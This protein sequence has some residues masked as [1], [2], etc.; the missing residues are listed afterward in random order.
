MLHED[1][2]TDGEKKKYKKEVKALVKLIQFKF[3]VVGEHLV[4]DANQLPST[5]T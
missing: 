1:V 2:K 5:M 4:Y 3:N